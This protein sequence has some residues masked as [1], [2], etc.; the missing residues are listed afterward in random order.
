M[1]SQ[2]ELPRTRIYTNQTL[3]INAEVGLNEKQS[4][5]LSG[6]LR[7]K[8]DDKLLL[9]NG[10]DG[11]W[12]AR[13]VEI[14]KKSVIVALE[15]LVREQKNSPDIWLISAPL[16]N[17]KTEFVLE[18]STELG[19]SKFCPVKTNFTIV[20]KINAERL[21]LIAIEAS[22]QCERLDIPEILPITSLE[23]LLGS[24]DKTR[25]IIYGDESGASENAKELLPKLTKGSYAVLIGAEG[26]FSNKELEILRMLPFATGISMGARIM[27]AD[28]A[29]IAA[30]TLVQAWV[31]DWEDKPAFRAGG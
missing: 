21:R 24:W 25:Q 16:K 30:L 5:Y 26:G 10:K 8:L 31:G 14:S 28:T 3:A 9:F 17:S 15:K 1:A 2:I 19:I 22:E 18:K 13:I 7:Q 29:T 23:K 27:R 12:L 6:V 20:D 4:H 11:E